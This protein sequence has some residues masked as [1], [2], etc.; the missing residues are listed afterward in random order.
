MFWSLP[1]LYLE[2]PLLTTQR[3]TRGKCTGGPRNPIP[4]REA[5][6]QINQA[7]S[8][9]QRMDTAVAGVGICPPLPHPMA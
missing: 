5:T 9:R 4:A 2:L 7:N 8:H 3:G 1:P 6:K